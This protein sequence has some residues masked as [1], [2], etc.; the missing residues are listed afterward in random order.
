[1]SQIKVTFPDGASKSFAAGISVLEVAK[2]ISGRLAKAALVAE[3]DRQL[4]D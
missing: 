3:I 2:S 4:S 1:M